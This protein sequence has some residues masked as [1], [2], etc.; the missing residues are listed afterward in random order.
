MHG[1][2]ESALDLDRE[3]RLALDCRQHLVPRSVVYLH[4]QEP[5]WNWITECDTTIWLSCLC[6]REMGLFPQRATLISA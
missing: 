4:T 3:P 1:P 6:T 2:G 5:S